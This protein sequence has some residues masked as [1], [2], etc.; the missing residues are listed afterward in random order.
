M[1]FFLIFQLFAANK[2]G[3]QI[4]LTFISWIWQSGFLIIVGFPPS[5]LFF[6]FEF[7]TQFSMYTSA[8]SVNENSWQ[9]YIFFPVFMPFTSY[10]CLIIFTISST[11]LNW[12]D[13]KE[14]FCLKENNSSPLDCMFALGFVNAFIR[15]ERFSLFHPKVRLFF[16]MNMWWVLSSI[17]L[18]LLAWSHN[19]FP[20]ILWCGELH[21]LIF[22]SISNFHDP[23]WIMFYLLYILLFAYVA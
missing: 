7:S 9:F 21:W 20:F 5:F 3:T 13:K 14:H 2:Q 10:S 8:L 11:M 19:F 18:H 23:T 22:D 6:F 12:R 17:F 15:L 1:A 16:F 4:I